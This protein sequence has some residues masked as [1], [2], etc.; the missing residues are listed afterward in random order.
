MRTY[1]KV[2]EELRAELCER[3]GVNR[4]SVWKALN[5][6][7]NK[8]RPEAVR[9][10]ALEHGGQLIVEHTV[11]NIESSIRERD[12]L[13]QSFGNGVVLVTSLKDSSSRLYKGNTLMLSA[14]AVTVQGWGNMIE[15]A[16]QLAQNS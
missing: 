15:Q 1:I 9:Q 10:Y 4:I 16:Q 6:L 2:S 8:E 7:T 5:Y 13:I 3:F 14:D 12:R 11:P